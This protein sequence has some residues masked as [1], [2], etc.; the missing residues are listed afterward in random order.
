MLQTQPTVALLIDYDNLEIGASYDIP[1]R[2]LI[3]LRDR[4][5]QHY[6]T[7]L[8]AR[9]YAEWNNPSERLAVFESRH[10]AMLRAGLPRRSRPSRSESRRHSIDGRRRGRPV[11]LCP[12]C[13]GAG[14]QR[15]RP[16]A[17]R[18][19]GA[20][21]RHPHGR[22]RQRPHRA[23]VAAPGRRVRDLPGTG[24]RH[25]HLRGRL[26]SAPGWYRCRAAARLSLG[27]HGGPRTAGSP[28]S[29]RTTP[30]HLNLWLSGLHLQ[31]R[32]PC[33]DPRGHS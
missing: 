21:A 32:A 16:A 24:Q 18:P 23:T 7:V 14:D 1:G 25:G 20:P 22:C 15:Q 3:W 30:R 26:F 4:V 11:P 19:S 28:T 5:V 17:D 33:T 6:G 8:I 31:R 2:P 9:A 13:P 12:R 10:R 27:P 29:R